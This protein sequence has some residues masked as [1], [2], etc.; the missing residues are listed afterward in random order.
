M[1]EEDSEIRDPKHINQI[2][3]ILRQEYSRIENRPE[4]NMRF[5]YKV[6]MVPVCMPSITLGVTEAFEDVLNGVISRKSA[7]KDLPV[8]D[9]IE[10]VVNGGSIKSHSYIV[11]PI[12]EDE[13]KNKNIGG[14]LYVFLRAATSG[15]RG[16]GPSDRRKI[17]NLIDSKIPTITQKVYSIDDTADFARLFKER[18]PIVQF[19][20]PQLYVNIYPFSW[21]K[22]FI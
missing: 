3:R 19:S 6:I 12:E 16:D 2:F 7:P 10:L 4:D 14:P 17:Q 1:S 13:H 9:V 18:G 20:I 15:Y 22:R 8:A 11:A 5:S 21:D